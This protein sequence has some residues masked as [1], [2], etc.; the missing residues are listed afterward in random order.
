MRCLLQR[1]SLRAFLGTLLCSFMVVVTAHAQLSQRSELGFGL[2]TFNYTGDLVRSYNFAF[3]K[4][5][6]TVLYR[7]NLSKVVSVRTSLTGGKLGASDKID[8]LDAFAAKRGASFNVFLLE[9]SG[10]F[11]YHFLDWRDPKRHLRFTPYLF[12]GVGLF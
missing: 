2:G 4:P 6:A 12:A 5:A 9:L 11:E 1:F 3:S 8:P 10:V 7:L